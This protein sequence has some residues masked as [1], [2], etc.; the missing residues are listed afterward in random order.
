MLV[1]PEPDPLI[2]VDADGSSTADGDDLQLRVGIACG[3]A[4]ER[5]GDWYGSPVNQ[6]SRVTTVARP[7]SVLVTDERPGRRRATTGRGRYARERKLKGVG[8]VKL[9]RAR[10]RDAG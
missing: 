9:F 4:L 3:P 6:A 2:D 5:A 7:G 10:P 8:E 1:A